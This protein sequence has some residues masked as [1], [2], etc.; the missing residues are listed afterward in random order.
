MDGFKGFGIILNSPHLASVWDTTGMRL[1]K[2][3]GILVERYRGR[4]QERM[5]RFGIPL[6]WA[7]LS[8]FRILGGNMRGVR[9]SSRLHVIARHRGIGRSTP[10]LN[11][12]SLYF[13]GLNGGRGRR[14]PMVQ[15]G[16]IPGS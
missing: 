10:E 7:E 11:P 15:T 9:E 8:A 3:F 4:L 6:G 14:A 2:F 16:Q 1:V 13:S 12:L 5:S